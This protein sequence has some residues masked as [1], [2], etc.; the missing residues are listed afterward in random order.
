MS[1][2]G[3]PFDG[4]KRNGVRL[5]V[6]PNGGEFNEIVLN[7]EAPDAGTGEEEGGGGRGR[8]DGGREGDVFDVYGG[9]GR[10]RHW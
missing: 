4:E 7:L 2:L 10:E 6:D 3:V 8:V 5:E 1:R 9:Y